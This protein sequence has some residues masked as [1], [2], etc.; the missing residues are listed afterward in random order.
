MHIHTYAQKNLNTYRLVYTRIR[1]IAGLFLTIARIREIIILSLK[2]TRALI[3]L[4][5]LSFLQYIYNNERVN[6]FYF[7]K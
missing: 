2:A 7:T 6:N 5:F 3:I 4:F 1:E